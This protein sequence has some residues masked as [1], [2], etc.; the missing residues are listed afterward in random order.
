[1]PELTGPLKEALETAKQLAAFVHTHKETPPPHD[2]P[3]A[4]C[5]HPVCKAYRAFVTVAYQRYTLPTS[6]ATPAPTTLL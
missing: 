4:D 5:Q 2:G 6:A 1:M 3:L